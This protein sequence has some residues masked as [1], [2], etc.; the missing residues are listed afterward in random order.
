MT[1]FDLSDAIATPAGREW[2]VRQVDRLLP[3]YFDPGHSPEQHAA[4]LDGFAEVLHRQ[5]RWAVAQALMAWR[6]RHTNR[7]TPAGLLMLAEQ[8]HA[9]LLAEHKRRN[10]T[11]AET[12][13]PKPSDEA[14]ARIRA[15]YEAFRGKAEAEVEQAPA[16]VFTAR[17]SPE[18]LEA[19]RGAN[20]LI[21]EARAARDAKLKATA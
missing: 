1:T 11:P 14:R 7:P 20:R 15:A 5:P 12:I 16:F 3:T 2:T 18:E 21:V 19:E 9:D 4:I 8:A 13:P 10:P 6:A 17:P